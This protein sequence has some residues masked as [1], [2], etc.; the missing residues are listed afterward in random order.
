MQQVNGIYL[1]DS[2]THFPN[3]I[4]RSPMFEGKGT[5]Q[6]NKLQ[7]AMPYVR[8]KGLAIDVG[9]HVGLW[10]RVLA[11]K[12]KFVH[13]IEMMTTYAELLELNV[14]GLSNVFIHAGV[15]LGAGVGDAAIT[16]T[17]DN[18][19]NTRI[20]PKPSPCDA[21]VRM[22]SLDSMFPGDFTVDFL[23]IDVEGYEQQVVIGATEL[24]KRSKPVMVVEQKGAHAERYGCRTGEVIDLLK[25]WGAR[26]QWTMS[27]DHCLTW[28]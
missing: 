1:P 28:G 8:N 4:R 15:A 11:H 22:W 14:A 9:A 7:A 6:L 18:S 16:R 27:G 2:D 26:V 21:S 12:F 25:A 3:M 23:K 10:S 13:A 24:I 17:E 5:Y 20:S 19:G